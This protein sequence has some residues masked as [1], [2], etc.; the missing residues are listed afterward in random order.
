[1][2]TLCSV[3]TGVALQES[4]PAT[5][6]HSLPDPNPSKKSPGR[7]PACF[8]RVSALRTAAQAD[9]F[10][11]SRTEAS[12]TLQPGAR[13]LRSA[14]TFWRPNAEFPK[15]SCAH[16]SEGRCALSFHPAEEEEKG[17][18]QFVC[19]GAPSAAARGGGRGVQ[20]Q[21][22]SRLG[23]REQLQTPLLTHSKKKCH[24]A[25]WNVGAGWL[26]SVSA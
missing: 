15:Q 17:D 20:K 23:R 5:A 11:L 1:M 13:H 21:T 18:V 6:E 22:I 14:G 7:K 8:S 24:P 10:Q 12:S 3:P 16:D 4:Y 19:T 2:E 26:L 9:W 25:Y